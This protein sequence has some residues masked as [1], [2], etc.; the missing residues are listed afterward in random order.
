M[1]DLYYAGLVLARI[2]HESGQIE[3]LI[4]GTKNAGGMQELEDRGDP[5]RTISREARQELSVRIPAR[6]RLLVHVPE[7]DFPEKFFYFVWFG[8]CRGALRSKPKRDD[9][10]ELLPSPRWVT[11][12]EYKKLLIHTHQPVIRELERLGYR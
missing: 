10:G 11:F 5:V 8:D 3:F 1:P 6:P 12:E 7:S 2:N 4:Q 9:D